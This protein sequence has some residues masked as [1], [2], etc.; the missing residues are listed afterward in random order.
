M[1]RELSN[2]FIGNVRHRPGRAQCSWGN[3]A[4]IDDWGDIAAILVLVVSVALAG[5]PPPPPPPPLS[6]IKSA[7]EAMGD[8][9][10][11]TQGEAEVA[12]HK[13][14]KGVEDMNGADIAGKIIVTQRESNKQAKQ[15][16]S[17]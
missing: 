3:T 15:A 6:V 5:P 11:C 8:T 14:A 1:R 2:N 17:K 12:G 9:A 4:C 10:G 16:K 7:V 13:R